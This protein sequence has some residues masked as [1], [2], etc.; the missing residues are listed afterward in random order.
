M[1]LSGCRVT[2]LLAIDVQPL[3]IE[4]V[5]VF[6]LGNF[7]GLIV[8]ERVW[9]FVPGAG[10]ESEAESL[11]SIFKALHIIILCFSFSMP[12][13]PCQSFSKSQGCCDV[14]LYRYQD[15]IFIFIFLSSTSDRYAIWSSSAPTECSTLSTSCSSSSS[16]CCPSNRTPWTRILSAHTRFRSILGLVRD[17]PTFC[18]TYHQQNVGKR[19]PKV[20]S[21]NVVAFLLGHINLLA[22]RAVDFDSRSSNF[23]AHTYR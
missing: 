7:V 5:I 23:F 4:G 22:S 18:L 2:C 16:T 11:V 9:I 8:V 1:I 12:R 14:S 13:L 15:F 21:I 20:R 6:A 19:T 10:G 17:I 3:G